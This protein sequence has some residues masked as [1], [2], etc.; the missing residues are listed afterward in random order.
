MGPVIALGFGV[1][2]GVDGESL[3]TDRNWRPLAKEFFCTGEIDVLVRCAGEKAEREAFYRLW[4][5][6]EALAKASGQGVHNLGARPPLSEAALSA[7][8]LTAWVEGWSGQSG[9]WL[10]DL[11]LPGFEIGSIACV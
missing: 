2:L 9:Y 3:D 5:R 10:V 11:P 4:T 7:D 6:K 8:P 1:R